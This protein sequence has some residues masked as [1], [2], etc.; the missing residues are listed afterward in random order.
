MAGED[1]THSLYPQFAEIEAMP[2]LDCNA[3]ESLRVEE[4][5]SRAN[6]SFVFSSNFMAL[7]G[8]HTYLLQSTRF[9]ERKDWA[10]GRRD[11]AHGVFF[12]ELELGIDDGS[13]I[14]LPI[15]AKPYPLFERSRAVHEFAA[16]EYFQNRTDMRSFFP[17]G[18]WVTSVGEAVILTAFEET[19]VSLDNVD[20]SM[21][22]EDALVEHFDLFTALQKSAQTL[23]RLHISGL[24]HRDAQIKN[25]AVDTGEEKAVRV[26]DL[27]TLERID[28]VEE[29]SEIKWQQ[30]VSRDLS[31]L[32]SSVRHRGYLTSDRNDDAREIVRLAL[33]SPHSA[34]L[35][36]PSNAQRLSAEN[37]IALDDISEMILAGV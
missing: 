12:G 25:M 28:G 22:G 23:A 33:L 1:M 13:T 21:T 5:L 17:I 4:Q 9:N 26:I 34:M 27:T 18:F 35:R 36:H 37:I 30:A 6:N 8:L 16:L 32:V 19:V 7:S 2:N 15:A 11:S 29:S 3:K 31:T 14:D 10:E 24:I 20:W